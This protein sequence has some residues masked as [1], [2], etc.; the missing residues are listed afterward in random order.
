M[1]R[2]EEVKVD[3]SETAEIV[4]VNPPILSDIPLIKR[5]RQ[6]GA[7][8]LENTPPA[9]SSLPS[10]LRGTEGEFLDSYQG[11]DSSGNWKI[12]PEILKKVI[13]DSSGNYYKIIKPEYDFLEKYALPLPELH[14]LER[15][16][17]G[18]KK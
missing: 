15:I 6:S 7:D 12:N 9:R 1:W 3:I 14:W 4:Y 5:D 18:L 17:V 10:Q 2:N 11:F 8:I 13:R 16:K